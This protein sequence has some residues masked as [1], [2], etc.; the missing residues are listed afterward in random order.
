MKYFAYGSNLNRKQMRE[1]CPESKP[2]TIAT[3]PNYKL[4]FTGWSR[5]WRGGTANIKGFQGEKVLGAVYEVNEKDMRRLDKHEGCPGTSTRLDI[6]VFT[7][8]GDPTEAVTYIKPS[9]TEETKPAPQY[10]AIMKQGCKDWR[11]I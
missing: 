7:E 1:R 4:A 10:I 3:L 9:Q 6:I 5:Q 11:I 8:N 2:V